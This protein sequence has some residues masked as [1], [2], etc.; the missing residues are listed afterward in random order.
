VDVVRQKTLR[1]ESGR[2]RMA[3][4]VRLTAWVLSLVCAGVLFLGQTPSARGEHEPPIQVFDKRKAVFEFSL[5]DLRGN[6]VNLKDFRGKVVFVNFWASWCVPCREEMP[7]MERLYQKYKGQ[8]L[9]MLAVNYR[10]SQKEARAF[11][12]ELKLTFPALLDDGMVSTLYGVFALPAT[13][14]V[15]RQGKS[16]ARVLGARDWMSEESRV[17]IEQLLDEK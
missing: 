12:E 10:E 7:S 5:P 3:I 11:V 9:V 1:E 2:W 13:Y 16:A 6:P 14:L 15:D 8:G 17:V 4:S